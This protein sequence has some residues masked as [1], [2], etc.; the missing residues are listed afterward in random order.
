MSWPD[1]INFRRA[2]FPGL[3]VLF[4]DRIKFS[5]E[6]Y[7]NEFAG[8]KKGVWPAEFRSQ[9]KAKEN[10]YVNNFAALKYV[11]SED[12][13][14]EQG[15][16]AYRPEGRF[17]KWQV[18]LILFPHVEGTAVVAHREPSPLA[19]VDDGILQGI[20]GGLR[21]Y[22]APPDEHQPEE[23]KRIARELLDLDTDANFKGIRNS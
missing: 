8:V 12:R 22:F 13:V 21:H 14:Y 3:D 1:L 16:Y 15:S 4:R 11:G 9:L 19:K 2:A 23:G 20:V 5:F 17:G 6:K 18:H 7:E 10:V